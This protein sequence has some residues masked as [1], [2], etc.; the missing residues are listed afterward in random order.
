MSEVKD[1]T[2]LN[3]LVEGVNP[4]DWFETRFLTR[5]PD[6]FVRCKVTESIER[7]ELLEWLA[8]YTH[9]RFAIATDMDDKEA[10]PFI[11]SQANVLAFEDP[12]EAT[13]YTLTFR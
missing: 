1:Q 7:V 9:G 6:H 3:E 8:K 4:M 10:N 13:L 2:W 5:I 11:I 12:Q